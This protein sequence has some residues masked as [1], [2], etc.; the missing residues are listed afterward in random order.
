VGTAEL[1]LGERVRPV[2]EAHCAASPL[3]RGIRQIAAWDASDDIMS[4]EGVP[5]G[6][7]YADPD[8]RAGFAVLADMDLSFDAYH[9]H[10]QTPQLTALAR[11]FPGARIVLNH[12][13][14][15]LGVG[16]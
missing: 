10:T 14:T 3:F 13:G 9:Y 2:L 12:L 11:A 1:R 7:L 4:F 8:F 15:P 16:P 6:N 5:D